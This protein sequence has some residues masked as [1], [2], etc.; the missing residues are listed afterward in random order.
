MTAH[1]RRLQR[2]TVAEQP[3]D[4][5]N[6][7]SVHETKPSPR[8][9]IGQLSPPCLGCFQVFQVLCCSSLHNNCL[10]PYY[11]KSAYLGHW[12][13]AQSPAD[14]LLVL[15]DFSK[16]RPFASAYLQAAQRST[17][18]HMSPLCAYRHDIASITPVCEPPGA[19]PVCHTLRHHC[20]PHPPNT[21]WSSNGAG[22]Q[23][24]MG[25]NVFI[26]TRLV[27][28]CERTCP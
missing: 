15:Q 22:C 8:P 6:K 18:H 2:T 4:C 16:P 5:T 12:T 20:L 27:Q 24:L 26:Q 1:R 10:A 3:N 11:R 14:V 19:V 23:H 17:A 28:C 7:Q 21:L 25:A 13:A 9:H